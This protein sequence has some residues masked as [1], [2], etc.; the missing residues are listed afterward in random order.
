MFSLSKVFL[1][2]ALI[3][4]VAPDCILIDPKPSYSLGLIDIVT[5]NT[6]YTIK[7]SHFNTIGTYVNAVLFLNDG[8]YL[9]ELFNESS[10]FVNGSYQY[11]FSCQYDSTQLYKIGIDN[12]RFVCY[13]DPFMI[14][15]CGNGI[16]DLNSGYYEECDFGNGCNKVCRCDLKYYSIY[17]S[18][19]NPIGCCG[20][21]CKLNHNVTFFNQTDLKNKDISA[22]TIRINTNSSIE[23]NTHTR[24]E[25][26]C[27]QNYGSII[28]DLN[29]FK[30]GNLIYSNCSIDLNTIKPI[31][32]NTPKCKSVTTKITN[33]K[34]QYIFGIDLNDDGC[35]KS[36]A[37]P[38]LGLWISISVLFLIIIIVI[39]L[40]TFHP[41][42][43]RKVFPWRNKD[44]NSSEDDSKDVI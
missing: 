25:A 37:I 3:P 21:I 40:A 12:D 17:D 27:I 33:I 2:I 10:T 8:T 5:C 35:N 26:G 18:N 41:A 39:P 28:I 4:S 44:L 15:M 43:K 34:Q 31:F 24:I 1:F 32:K 42:C 38:N 22:D 9:N 7:W 13:T 16:I 30:S 29:K 6:N 14:G 36:T 23:I 11:N 20:D 19:Q